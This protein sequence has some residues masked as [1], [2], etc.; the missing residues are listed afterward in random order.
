M[1]SNLGSTAR[2][3]IGRT[4]TKRDGGR[5]HGRVGAVL[6]ALLIASAAIPAFAAT[7][8]PPLWTAGGLDAG[9]TGAGQAARI[10]SDAS[11]NVAV[12]SG[13]SGGR[14]LAVTS[15]TPDGA[16]RWRSAVSPTTGTFVGDWVVAAPNGDFVAVGHNVTSSGSPIAITMVRYSPAGSLLWR[17]NIARTLPHVARLVVDS[18]GNAYLA[19]NAVGDG[20]D[21]QVHKYNPSG[22]LLW[23]QV[24]STGSLANDTATSLALSPDEA[25][26][27]VTGSITGG[28]SWITALYDTSTGT[29]KWLVNAPEGIA[30]RDVVVDA[31]RVYV[32]GLGNVGI[33]GYLTAIA[34]DRTTGAR[35]WRT[36]KKATDAT[37][38]AGLWMD[39]SPDGSL[40]VTGQATR[41]FLDWYTVAFETTGAVRWEAVRDGGLNTDEVPRGVLVMGDGTTVVTGPGGPNL[42][43]GFIQGVTAGY[44]PDGTL[45]WEAFSPLATVWATELPSGDVCATGGYDALVTCWRVS[46][47]TGN[48]APTAVMS[49]TPGTGDVPLT[50]AFDGSGSSD[51]DGAITSWSWSF[52]D[53]TAGTG[54][55]TSHVY[56]TAGTFTAG[57]TVT[58]DGGASSTATMPI[59]VSGPQTTVLVSSTTGGTV[60]GVGFADE[61]ILSVDATGVWS[62]YFDGSDVGLGSVDLDAAEQLG[63]GRILLSTESPVVLGGVS[64][65]DSDIISF[66]PSSIGST[67]AGAFSL[68]LSGS[69]IGLT[70]KTENVDAIAITPQGELLLSTGGRLAG[71]GLVAEDEDLVKV[72]GTALALYLD[73]SAIGLTANT[74]DIW[75]ASITTDSRIDF[76][77]Q[78]G[79]TLNTGLSG[80]AAA[81]GQCVAATPAPV[82]GCSTSSLVAETALI[83]FASEV[84]DAVIA[85]G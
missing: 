56:S 39:S 25:V 83:G 5:H 32:A 48:Q 31:G 64:Y 76:S 53:G 3:L 34:Y 54:A 7:A 57:L 71:G 33:A 69:T 43:G 65:D 17:V 4:M 80:S 78:G 38:A 27:A 74:E 10:A 41:G 58:D 47:E 36:D 18:A 72:T 26:V 70:T 35:L 85:S 44:S 50:V 81:V 2:S 6:L 51:P 61:D 30:A 12:V 55:T 16:F 29:R 21:I 63:D 79:F 19:F 77:A 1:R 20:Q 84:I 52:G 82:T 11:G 67:T 68:Y 13:P 8:L 28:A 60:G 75:G 59:V 22:V 42:P 23:S 14:D 37:G 49:A 46:D 15:Y 73:G 66:T 24:I 62:M 45:L 40:V 9:T